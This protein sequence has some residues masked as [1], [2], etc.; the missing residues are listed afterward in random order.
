MG[1]NADKAR[2]VLS[3]IFGKGW[4]AQ[5]SAIEYALDLEFSRG[6]M[7]GHKV[8]NDAIKE[9]AGDDYPQKFNEWMKEQ[10]SK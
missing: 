2:E 5:L 7:R 6:V 3:Q 9:M 8:A 10:E 1:E 4:K